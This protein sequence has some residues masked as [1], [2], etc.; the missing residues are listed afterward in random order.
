MVNYELL[1]QNIRLMRKAKNWTQTELACRIGLSCSFLGHIER[2]SRILSLETLVALAD[3]LDSSP[4]RLLGYNTPTPA[5]EE[6]YAVI[7]AAAQVLGS[8]RRT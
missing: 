6:V 2:G 7:S 4:D 5:S 8:M 3:A 1:G